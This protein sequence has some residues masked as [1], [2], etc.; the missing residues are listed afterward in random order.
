ILAYILIL[1]T[2][3][4]NQ[5]E[6]YQTVTLAPKPA[7][8]QIFPL[9]DFRVNTADADEPHFM[10]VK[11]SLAYDGQN[12]KLALELTERTQQIRDIILT[13]LNSKEKQDIDTE[14]EKEGLKEE[15]KKQ[16]NN[17]LTTGVIND[18]YY[19]QFIV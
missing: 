10:R 18:I 11:L 17:V 16:I 7:P 15:I 4:K 8:Y 9:D 14:S 12:K 6:I 13:I 5:E 19:D 3:S 1:S 2:K